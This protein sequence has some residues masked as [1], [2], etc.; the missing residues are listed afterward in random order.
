[1]SYSEVEIGGEDDIVPCVVRTQNA[2]ESKR[3]RLHKNF[4]V[5]WMPILWHRHAIKFHC[6]GPWSI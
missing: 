1:V 3:K 5:Y 6:N 2:T 4:V